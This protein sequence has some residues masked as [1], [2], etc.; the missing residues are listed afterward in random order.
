MINNKINNTPVVYTLP[1]AAKILR[2][3]KCLAYELAHKGVLP[4]IRLGERRMI[5]TQNAL[6]DFL[7]S[8]NQTA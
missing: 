2:I 6:N 8:Q 7:S 4:V 5:I 1:E 3:S